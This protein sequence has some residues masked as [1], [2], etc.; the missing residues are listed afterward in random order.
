MSSI[1]L[2]QY[3]EINNTRIVYNECNYRKSKNWSG[4]Q[5]ILIDTA[6]GLKTIFSAIEVISEADKFFFWNIG[7]TRLGLIS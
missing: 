3:R 2:L 5:L 4:Q 1:V 7:H 6:A